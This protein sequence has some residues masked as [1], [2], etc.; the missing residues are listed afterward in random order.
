[1]MAHFLDLIRNIFL[2]SSKN[3]VAIIGKGAS[4]HQIDTEKLAREYFIIA[5]NDAETICEA[6]LTVFHRE[7]LV[8]NLA[9]NGFKSKYYVA[10]SYLQLPEEKHI[11]APYQAFGQEGIEKIYTYFESEEFCILDINLLSAI[12]LAILYQQL[13]GCDIE[14]ALLGFDFYLD[15]VADGDMQGL[16]YRNAYLRTQESLLVSLLEFRSGRYPQVNMIHVGNKKYSFK[17]PQQF[18]QDLNQSK[19]TSGKSSSNTARYYEMLAKKQNTNSVI[20]VAELTNNHIGS[21]ERLIKMVELAHAAGAD[22]VKVQKRDI[23]TFYTEEELAAPYQSPFGTT[24]G[25]YRRAVEMDESMFETLEDVCARLNIPWFVSVLDWNSYLFIQKLECPIIKLPSTISNHRNYLK[26]VFEVFEGDL[27]V[28]TGF[29][30][31]AYEEFVLT[32]APR[33]RRLYLLQCTSS[34]PT[35]PQCCNI[36]VVRH[37]DTLRFN[38]PNIVPGYS[39]HDLGSMGCIM[40][41]AAGA[42]MIEKHVKL[43]ELDWVHFDS[44]AIDLYNNHFR[45]FVFDIRKAELMCGDY[46]KSILQSEHHKYNIN[47]KV[48]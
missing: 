24:L 30:D 36:N 45:N 46:L 20:I 29:T 15:A 25:D 48:N 16:D 22:M 35:P 6:D 38:Y 5:L 28:S 17:T 23:D 4:I 39:S 12:K 13:R 7:D 9:E 10:P 47:D 40:A 31:Q 34:Y 1:M 2:K 33:D 3:N 43:G 14:L 21:K 8:R 26:K 44:V 11:H 19:L 18:N 41:V 27:V 37:Y 32:H 42:R